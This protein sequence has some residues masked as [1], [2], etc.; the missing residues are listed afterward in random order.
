[1][2]NNNKDNFCKFDAKA[3]ES[4][5]LGYSTYSKAYKVYNRRTLVVE[6]SIYVTFDEHNFLSR[7]I[8]RN[9]VKE[10]EQSL[11]K[12]DIQT[13]SNKNPQ[14]DEEVQ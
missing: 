11:K 4:I 12:L 9:D 10:V 1:M 14:K 8:I 13:S 7:N 3:D 6:E 2:L 5:F